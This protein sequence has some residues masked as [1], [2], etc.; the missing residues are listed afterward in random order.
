MNMFNRR[1]FLRDFGLSAAAL[2]FVA[3]LPGLRAAE[4]A[5]AKQRLVIMFSPNGIIQPQFWPDEVGEEFTFKRILAPLEP[6][7]KQTLV[8]KG[9]SNKVR[10]DGDNHMR[11]MS[12][13]VTGVELF[14]GNIQGG[15]DTPAGWA[16]GISIDQELK[17]F[18]Q[19]RPETRT[20]FGSLELGVAV[21]HRADP[22][23]RCSYAGPNQP[24]APIDD[25][26]HLFEK[27]YG[28]MRDKET[29]ASILDEVSDDLRS[30]AAKVSV[31]DKS[32]LDQHLTFVREMERELQSKDDN[33][34]GHAAPELDPGVLMD[35]DNIPRIM[36]MQIDLLVNAL[37]ND[38]TRIAT[39]QFTNS[40]GGARM[41]WLGVDEGHHSLS[42]EPDNNAEA[43]EKL[44]KINTWLCEQFAS[45]VRKLA[46]TPEPG[47]TG[48][49]LDHTTLLWTNELGKGN[50]HTLDNIPFVMVGGGCG[51]QMG[52][53]MNFDRAAHNRLWLA[54]ANAFGHELK[55]FGNP[56]LCGGGPLVLS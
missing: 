16:K 20:R 24:L 42:H 5:A 32:L 56:D 11:G 53:S 51:F 50:S 37:A 54:I 26:Y 40:V 19:S 15:S 23:T 46:D 14:P 13:L 39:L 6:F 33:A 3:G 34:L 48:S 29:V 38:M 36:R 8:L 1:Q 41:R 44:T 27:L 4:G 7:K 30:L 2:P 47:G 10:G 21:P 45:L 12:C 9:I 43:Q 22:W 55:T 52:R 25:P 18:L 17:N 28:R 31:E 49:M 35:N